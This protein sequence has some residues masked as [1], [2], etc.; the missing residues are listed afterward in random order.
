M[1][2]TERALLRMG[3]ADN[4]VVTA[5]EQSAQPCARVSRYADINSGLALHHGPHGKATT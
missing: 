5:T 4:S 1:P 3:F 2:A